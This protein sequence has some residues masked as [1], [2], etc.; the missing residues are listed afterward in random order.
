MFRLLSTL[1]MLSA[2]STGGYWVWKNVPQVRAFVEEHIDTSSFHTLEVRHTAQQIMETRSLELLRD[3]QHTFLKPSLLFYPYLLLEVKYTDSNHQTREGVILWGLDDGEMVIDASTWEKTHGFQ[4][5]IV[6]RANRND[7]RILNALAKKR[8]PMRRDQL[9][10]ALHVET[11]L[12]DQWLD[13][14]REKKLVV[15]SGGNYRLHFERPK[16]QVK[17]QTHLNDWLVT[18]PYKNAEKVPKRYTVGQVESIAQ[19]AFGNDFTIRNKKEVFLPV[20][21]II[22]QNPDGSRFTSY[23]NALNGQ[24]LARPKL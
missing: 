10:D 16:L 23:W 8:S 24:R 18:K 7:F 20:Y 2:F 12:L 22:V 21:S 11:D 13:R 4:D 3:D 6:A 1:L 9:S 5:C 14:C 19:A 15:Q 17:P